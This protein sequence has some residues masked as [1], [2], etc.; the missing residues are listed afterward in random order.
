[1]S[2]LSNLTAT[3]WTPIEG[4]FF[5]SSCDVCESVAW[6]A[7]MQAPDCNVT[8]LAGVGGAHSDSYGVY[9]SEHR[10]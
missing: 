6:F 8:A 2:T 5:K 7:R 9:C 3:G 1:M 10:A 4:D